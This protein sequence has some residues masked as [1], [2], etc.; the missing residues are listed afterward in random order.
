MAIINNNTNESYVS[1]P[2]KEYERLKS[3]QKTIENT[4][5]IVTEGSEIITVFESDNQLV[6]NLMNMIK[7]KDEQIWELQRDIRELREKKGYKPFWRS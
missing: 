1:I 7:V 4:R 2:L 5:R 3:D 6:H